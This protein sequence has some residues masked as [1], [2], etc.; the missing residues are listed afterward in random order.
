MSDGG[1]EDWNDGVPLADP[2]RQGQKD[3]VCTYTDAS[4]GPDVI[5][6]RMSSSETRPLRHSVT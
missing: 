1:A 2:V 4:W 6:S 5:G 3:A